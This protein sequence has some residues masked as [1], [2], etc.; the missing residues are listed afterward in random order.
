MIDNYLKNKS[1]SLCDQAVHL[2][3]STNRWEMKEYI[4]TQISNGVSIICDR[5]AYSGV[6]YS[7]AKGLDSEWWKS[8]D[9][10]LPHPDLVLFINTTIEQI[11][12]RSGF[13][14]ERYEKVEF[15]GK[16][17]DS[18]LKLESSE[19]NWVNI[20]GNEKTVEEI[21]E[22]IVDCVMEKYENLDS[23]EADINDTLFL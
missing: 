20:E 1:S 13:G 15:Q 19:P 10:G 17:F 23:S 16:V 5:Y 11:A 21:H 14:D 9:A 7:S 3:F 12:L 18:Y 6:A 4:H 8:P 2:L 22:Q